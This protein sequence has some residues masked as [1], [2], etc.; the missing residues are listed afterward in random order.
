MSVIESD[1]AF[2]AP[3]A[4]PIGAQFFSGRTPLNIASARVASQL[5]HRAIS[6]GLLSF[7]ARF[8]DFAMLVALSAAIFVVYVVPSD[9]YGW[10]YL[11]AVLFLPAVTIALIGAFN[12]YTLA[13]YR[14]LLPEAGRAMLMWTGAFGAFTLLLFFLKMGE[15]FSRVWLAAWFLSGIV[16]LVLV[17]VVLHRQ[18]SRWTESG[19]LERRAVLVG[20][21]DEA[22]ELIRA[23]ADEPANDIR[24]CGIFDDR[25]DERVPAL[26]EGYAKLGRIDELLEFGRQAEIDMLIVALPVS[27]EQRLVDLLKKLWVLPIDIRLSA[28]ASKLRF[29]PRAYSYVGS[30]PFLDL[31][32]K[33]IAD[34]DSLLKRAFDIV[35]ASLALIAL[36]PLM[37]LTMAAIRLDSAG[38]VFFR[39]RRYGFNN[40]PIEVFKF[41]SMYHHMADPAAKQVVTKDD[42]RVTRVGRFIRKTS[43]DELPQLFNVILGSLSLVGPRPHAVTAHMQNRLWEDVVDGYFARHRVKPGITGWAQ[44]NGWRGEVTSEDKIRRRVEHDL[45]YIENWSVLFDLYILVLTP[46]RL[47][48]SEGAY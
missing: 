26:K 27:A 24:I 29:R 42:P 15:E 7:L 47:L 23:L 13:A 9:G 12:G 19:V 40:E 34:W 41:R 14:R 22:V 30:V 16:S 3:A 48:N 8:A 1:R 6:P 10:R 38:P 43:I 39:Q 36:S 35:V 4:G 2:A 37:L 20:G 17:R 5:R 18:V 32:D 11:G 21:G 44:I 28:G 33:P 25:D 46:F 45:F 31:F